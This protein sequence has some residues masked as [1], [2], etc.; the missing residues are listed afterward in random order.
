[1]NEN[2]VRLVG[3]VSGECVERELPSGDLVAVARLVVSR[4][5]VRV[6]EDGRRGQSVDVVDCAAWS[7][8][9]RRSVSGWCAGDTV[10]VEGALRRRFFR[11]GGRTAARV[12]VEIRR[13]RVVRR[14][15]GG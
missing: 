13:C 2:A 12:E 10:L 8:R 11:S 9:T 3:Q 4:D 15:S 6:R 1:M 5:E 7:P 14:G